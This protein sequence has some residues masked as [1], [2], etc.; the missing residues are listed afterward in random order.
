[1]ATI[2]RKDI[3]DKIAADLELSSDLVNDVLVTFFD[4]FRKTILTGDKIELRNF[5]V[6]QMITRQSKMARNLKTNEPIQLP[7]RR[8]LSFKPGREMKIRINS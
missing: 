7:E 5:G 2:K 8:Y 1:M 6:F 3:C 4:V